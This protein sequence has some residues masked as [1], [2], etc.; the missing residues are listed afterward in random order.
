MDNL[1]YCDFDQ[2]LYIIQ[3]LVDKYHIDKDENFI[4]I[5]NECFQRLKE[6]TVEDES[7]VKELIKELLEM[8]THKEVDDEQSNLINKICDKIVLKFNEIKKELIN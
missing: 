3:P 1:V 2:F 6:K 5:T 7:T 4:S 8:R